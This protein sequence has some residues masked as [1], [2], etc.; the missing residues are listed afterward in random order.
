MQVEIEKAVRLV[1]GT[2]TEKVSAYIGNTFLRWARTQSFCARF[3]FSVLW[4]R[5]CLF[6]RDDTIIK[7]VGYIEDMF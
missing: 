4:I 1:N 7:L 5:L 3:V 2:R 6:E